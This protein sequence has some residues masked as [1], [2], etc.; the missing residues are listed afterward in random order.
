MFAV[1]KKIGMKKGNPRSGYTV[2]RGLPP[3]DYSVL[4]LGST[5][6][7]PPKPV[8]LKAE[9][10]TPKTFPTGSRR[11]GFKIRHAQFEREIELTGSLQGTAGVVQLIGSG[12]ERGRPFMALEMLR[13]GKSLFEYIQENAPLVHSEGAVDTVEG[14]LGAPF[15]VSFLWELGVPLCRAL[16]QIHGEGIVHRDLNPK[17]ILLCRDTGRDPVI[18]DFGLSRRLDETSFSR[19]ELGSHRTHNSIIG[20]P[21]Y[22]SP[23]VLDY[24]SCGTFA[25]DIY[26]LGALLFSV[27]VGI[28]PVDLMSSRQKELFFAFA[29]MVLTDEEIAAYDSPNRLPAPIFSVLQ[30]AMELD[31]AQRFQSAGEFADALAGLGS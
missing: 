22:A 29:G 25:S 27:T 1:G 20:S 21:G 18:I 31:P 10:Y 11:C 13:R 7:R 2:K 17:N 4:A 3:T 14:G 5:N 30:R 28:S 15:E 26:S 9:R 16:E 6:A 24:S 19:R 8:V 23:E 12:K